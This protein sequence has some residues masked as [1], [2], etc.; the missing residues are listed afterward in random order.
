M[1]TPSS[2][3]WILPLISAVS[4]SCSAS[5]SASIALVYSVS[6]W[7]RRG[8]WEG[9]DTVVPGRHQASH[10]H[11]GNMDVQGSEPLLLPTLRAR[12][13]NPLGACLA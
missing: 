4:A 13:P 7:R 11:C 5:V 6:A 2:A 3:S 12:T 1:G 8:R 10:C 9:E